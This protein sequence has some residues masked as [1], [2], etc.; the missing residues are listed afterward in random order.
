MRLAALSLS[1]RKAPDPVAGFYVG[2]TILGPK[3]EAMEGA[4]GATAMRIVQGYRTQ[5]TTLDLRKDYTFTLDNDSQDA[6]TKTTGT[7][8]RVGGEILA[9][10]ESVSVDGSEPQDLRG[11]AITRL[12]IESNGKLTLENPNQSPAIDATTIYSRCA[13]GS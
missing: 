3:V 5:K 7:W 12:R 8:S 11:N 1:C 13:A 2:A 9:K 6:E 10:G 4:G